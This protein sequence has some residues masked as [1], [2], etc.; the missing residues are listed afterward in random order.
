MATEEEKKTSGSTLLFWYVVFCCSSVGMTI[1]N[2]IVK[3]GSSS[4]GGN[5]E[6]IMDTALFLWQNGL[7][8]VINYSMFGLFKR[9]VVTDP[10]WD[11]KPFKTEHWLRLLFPTINFGLILFTRCG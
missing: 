4:I 2:K 6:A 10:T 1:G 5:E 7:A 11:M 9:G 8:I 3:R